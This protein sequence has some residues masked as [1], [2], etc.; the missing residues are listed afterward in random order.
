[1]RTSGACIGVYGAGSTAPSATL[2]RFGGPALSVG[3]RGGSTAAG[4]PPPAQVRAW[5]PGLSAQSQSAVGA[6]AVPGPGGALL[7]SM[8]STTRLDARATARSPAPGIGEGQP[9]RGPPTDAVPSG[10]ASEGPAW[11][12]PV[13]ARG[14]GRPPVG[15]PSPIRLAPQGSLSSRGV[16]AGTA[17][18]EVMP[19]LYKVDVP[20]SP[21]PTTNSL[22]NGAAACESNN[23]SMQLLPGD[24]QDAAQHTP[25][26]RVIQLEAQIQEFHRQLQRSKDD[27]D[28]IERRAAERD[29]EVSDLH[30]RVAERDAELL[31]LRAL[32][33]STS[34]PPAMP[35]AARVAQLEAENAW[36]RDRV[37]AKD[38]LPVRAPRP[39]CDADGA[40]LPG[41]E[42]LEAAARLVQ[43]AARPWI[44]KLLRKK[45]ESGNARGRWKQTLQAVED[46]VTQALESAINQTDVGRVPRQTRLQMLANALKQGVLRVNQAMMQQT[47]QDMRRTP[48]SGHLSPTSGGSEHG[49]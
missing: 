49:G 15:D 24:G 4:M 43:R 2:S 25:A 27:Q 5:S 31:R 10:L 17:G 8:R 28:A 9:V 42:V 29:A 46:G 38:K 30:A 16:A 33:A 19:S 3:C 6:T 48:G 11:S 45:R 20:V 7:G 35:D 39:A 1:M 22:G 40:A 23:G 18:Q 32:H 21:M 37:D 44:G 47:L 26:W 12:T 13:L 41:D 36:L 14:R 34:G